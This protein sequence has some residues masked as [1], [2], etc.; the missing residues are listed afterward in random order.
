[1]NRFELPR[2]DWYDEDGR[3]YKDA[4]IENFNAIE[5]KLNEI[6][7]IDAF[8]N[9]LPDVSSIS[10]EDIDEE[11]EED[12]VLNL[13]SFLEIT[14]LMNYPLELQFSGTK[15]SKIAYWNSSYNYTIRTNITTNLT[16]TNKYLLFNFTT[17]TASVTSS[18]ASIPTG[19]SLIGVY[20]D[21]RVY[22][23][24]TP[25]GGKLNLMYLLGNMKTST[26]TIT[27][28]KANNHFYF[29]NGQEAAITRV[30]SKAGSTTHTFFPEGKQ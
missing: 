24:S 18:M 4:L 13:K 10:L 28:G 20:L 5:A 6:N 21:G 12:K 29:S 25:Y 26:R 30:E 17:G 27:I 14:G 16:K 8:S 11:S 1:M 23:L 7:A 15:I 3:I 9:P 22:N 2:L 19:T